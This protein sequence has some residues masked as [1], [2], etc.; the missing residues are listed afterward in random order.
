MAFTLRLQGGTK[1]FKI[2]LSRKYITLKTI[3]A[4]NKHWVQTLRKSFTVILIKDRVKSLKKILYLV[5]FC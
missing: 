5:W 4:K 3:N 1:S 2:R